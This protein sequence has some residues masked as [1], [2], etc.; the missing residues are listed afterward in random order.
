[1]NTSKNQ[2]KNYINGKWVK[3]SSEDEAEVIL[4]PDKI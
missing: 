2:L 3:S 1:M 4:P